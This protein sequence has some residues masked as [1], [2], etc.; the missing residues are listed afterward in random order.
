MVKKRFWGGQE[1]R[2]SVQKL[3]L[4]QNQVSDNG[5]SEQAWGW[6]DKGE[7]TEHRKAEEAKWPD[8]D[9]LKAHME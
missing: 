6:E 2:W 1:A 7:Y 8:L 9:V 3:L 5:G 4:V